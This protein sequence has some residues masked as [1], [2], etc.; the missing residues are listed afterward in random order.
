MGV[1]KV[2]AADKSKTLQAKFVL[3]KEKDQKFVYTAANGATPESVSN[4]QNAIAVVK[5]ADGSYRVATS[6]DTDNQTYVIEAGN[7]TIKGLDDATTYYLYEVKAQDGY[8]LLK[9]PV[10]FTINTAY[11]ADGS[12]LA[13]NKP[14]VIV[15]TAKESTTLSTV[16]E[17][18]S[19]TILPSTGGVGTTMFYVCGAVLISGAAAM[20]IIR[21][22][23]EEK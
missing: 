1:H 9:D 6:A 20:L 23:K 3:S 15:G 7:V 4:T 16:I 5:N 19:G 14:T 2:D 10:T 17:N 13:E 22:K 18:H 11:N 12:S 8:N 21:K